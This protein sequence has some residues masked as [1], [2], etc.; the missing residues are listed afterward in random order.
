MATD[1]MMG[2]MRF[3]KMKMSGL[4]LMVM[5]LVI[6]QIWMMIMMVFQIWMMRFLLTLVERHRYDG[7]GDNPAPAKTPDSCLLVFG[8]STQDRFGCPD[9]DGDGWSDPDDVWTVADGADAFVD[10]AAEWRDGDIDGIGDNSDN[11]PDAFNPNQ[12]DSDYWIGHP[13]FRDGEGDACDDDDDN[14]GVLDSDDDFK[15][16]QCAHLDTDSDGMPDFIVSECIPTGSSW[17]V[18]DL[19]VDND[20]DNDGISDIVEEGGL[21][22]NENCDW[23][24]YAEGELMNIAGTALPGLIHQ[25]LN[26][27]IGSQLH[28]SQSIQLRVL[29]GA[30]APLQHVT[31]HT[32]HLMIVMGTK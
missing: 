23:Q 12:L 5:V 31:F 32:M 27:D 13:S 15:F 17:T 29:N 1:I 11:C 16:D 25:I 3:L 9:S 24:W 14:D 10:N 6:T 22:T 4:I 30:L 28:I 19:I 26:L 20:D 2:M 8:P 7:F 18:T 21:F